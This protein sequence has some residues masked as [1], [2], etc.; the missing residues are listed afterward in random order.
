[1][2]K[3]INKIIDKRVKRLE[4]K[5]FDKKKE[6]AFLDGMYKYYLGYSE[7]TLEKRIDRLEEKIDLLLNHLKLEKKVVRE[8]TVLR[9]FNQLKGLD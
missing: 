5:I 8:K 1:M 2:K 9:K 7:P 3:F 6:S 4:N